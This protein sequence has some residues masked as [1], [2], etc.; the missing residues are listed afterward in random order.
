MTG[1]CS[2]AVFALVF[3]FE[4][5]GEVEVE[6]HGGELPHAAEDVDQL[7][8]DLGAVEGGFAGDVAVGD[9]AAVER[10]FERGGGLSQC[11]AEPV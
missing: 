8:V 5:G 1:R 4:A 7:D 2:L 6:L 11:S 9:A 10:V 3:E